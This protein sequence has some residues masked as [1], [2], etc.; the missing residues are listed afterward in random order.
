MAG[1]DLAVIGNC[2]IDSVISPTGRRVWFCFPGLD[3][4][5][6]FNALL[7]GTAP[8]LGYLDACLYG[9]TV[10]RQRY[11]PNAAVLETALTDAEGGK[12]RV[13]DFCPCFR[14]YGRMFRPPTLA[15]RIEPLAG[16]P[17]ITVALR[18]SFE[19]GTTAPAVRIGCNHMRFV[20]PDRVLRV[21]TDMPLSY[22][23]HE[24]NFVLD[25]PSICLSAPTRR[26]RR[27]WRCSPGNFWMRPSAI[28]GTGC[29]IS[30]C[31]STGRR[32]RSVP[33]SR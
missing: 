31:H 3:A 32:Q 24:A 17:R 19:Y 9:Q 13:L 11:L 20:G 33:S 15:R 26:C 6:V 4:A 10:T 21:T 1:L 16:R 25:R 30:T 12:A 27:H 22:L 29:A 23:G 5:S 18:P 2:T 14:R 8:E 7:G 28:G